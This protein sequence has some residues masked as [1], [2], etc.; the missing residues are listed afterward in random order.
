MSGKDMGSILEKPHASDGPYWNLRGNG[1]MVSTAGD[2]AEFYR[3]LF[4][5]EKL[6]PFNARNGMFDPKQPMGLAGSD[7]IN[8]FLYERIPD[9]GVEMIIASTNA[10][11]KSPV[12]R[13]ELAPILG[14]PSL[15]GG[16]RSGG[17]GD[18]ARAQGKPVSSE[19]SSVI[20]GF[21]SAVNSGNKDVVT[22]FIAEHYVLPAGTPSAEERATR[23][24][25]MHANLGALTVLSKTQIEN[26]PAQAVVKTD[27]E[28]QALLIF[29]VEPAAPF[30]IRRFGVQVGG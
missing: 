9:R 18:V 25:D 12:I 22:K 4:E 15:D 14:L 20:D 10:A 28:G 19:V 27:N 11:M 1:G 17:G 24:L 30:K 7:L 13:R 5:T 23:L 6:L 29:D 26:G 16:E 2:M 3:A 21:I 8:F